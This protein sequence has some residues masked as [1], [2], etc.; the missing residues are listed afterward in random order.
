MDFGY[1]NEVLFPLKLDVAPTIK[2]SSPAGSKVHRRQ[3]RLAGVPRGLHSRARRSSKRRCN[4][5]PASLTVCLRFRHG[6][7]TR[8]APGRHLA[9][10]AARKRQGRLPAHT[11][12]FRLGVET[13]QRESTAAFFPADQDILDNPAPQK[14][15]P[16]A[17]GLV[18]DLKKDASLTANPAQLNGVLELSGGRA[19]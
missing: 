2:T 4:C 5:S 12:G 10:A 1:E 17:K 8:Q 13:G 11:D 18:L 9:Y 7:G 16:T 15:T 14:V 19:L 6:C 3:G